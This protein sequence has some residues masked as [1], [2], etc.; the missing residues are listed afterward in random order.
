MKKLPHCDKATIKEAKINKYLLCLEHSD[1]K[2]KAKFFF[3]WGFCLEKWQ[4]FEQSL[5]QHPVE[6][7]VVKIETS[8]FGKKYIVECGLSTPNGYS[9]C[10][11][12]IWMI[13]D[14]EDIPRLVTAYPI[15]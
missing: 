5:R 1:G 13:E 7:E 6:H 8:D 15:D 10:I 11:R 4:I 12:S 3:G 2:S 9:P 14:G